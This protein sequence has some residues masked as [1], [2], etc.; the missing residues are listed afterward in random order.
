M[1]AEARRRDGAGGRTRARTTTRATDHRAGGT[2]RAASGGRLR[3]GTRR[4]AAGA[5]VAAAGMML[6]PVASAAP[7]ARDGTTADADAPRAASSATASESTAD[8]RWRWP[9]PPPHVITRPFIAPATP[10]G[11]GHRGADISADPGAEVLAPADGTVSFAGVVVDRPVISIR[12]ADGLVSS[13]EPVVP[14]VATG[15]RVTAGQVIGTVA[16]APRREPDG[17]I[18]LGARLQGEY[19]DPALLL[20]SLRHAVLLPLVP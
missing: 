3:R 1:R 10:Y 17:G 2:R 19:V 5:L 11:P 14:A 7:I 9:V 12:H 8:P 16:D 6:A 20:A 4:V 18:L 13:M 15:D